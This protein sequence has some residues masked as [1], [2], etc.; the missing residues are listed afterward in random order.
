MDG[1]VAQAEQ[2]CPRGAASNFNFNL[3]C[4]STDVMG[5]HDQRE[6]PNYW[7]YAHHFVLNDHLF[8]SSNSYSA[9]DHLY[10]VSGW[11]AHCSKP[12][13]AMSCKSDPTGTD[14]LQ[15]LYPQPNRPRHTSPPGR[16]STM[17]GLT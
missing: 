13:D 2:G 7:A 5:Y 6:I 9:V 15:T 17:T 3:N 14:D 11:S 16:H 12:F 4:A 8:A 1:F 10:L